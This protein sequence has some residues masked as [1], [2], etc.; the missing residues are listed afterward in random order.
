MGDG[1]A[2]V[3]NLDYQT[4]AVA[5]FVFLD[6]WNSVLA[7][8]RTGKFDCSQHLRINKSLFNLSRFGPTKLVQSSNKGLGEMY[9]WHYSI[10]RLNPFFY[11]IHIFFDL[12]QKQG[13]LIV[14][15]Q[16]LS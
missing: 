14:T 1:V 7:M 10:P 4:V 2:R 9:G 12:H 5:H 13:E 8:I 11:E 15:G 6:I 16:W 3:N